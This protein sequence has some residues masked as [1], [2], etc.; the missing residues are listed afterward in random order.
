MFTSL[1]LATL[2]ITAP[3]FLVVICGYFLRRVGLIDDHF[4]GMGSRMVFNFT[5]PILLFVSIATKTLTYGVALQMAGTGV[6]TTLIIW[7]FAAWLAKGWIEP[8]TDRGVVVMGSFRSNLGI[9]GLAYSFNA[10]GD[11]GV[12]AVAMYLAFVTILFNILS[13]VTLSRKQG[14][15]TSLLGTLQGI[16]RNP[17]IVAIALALVWNGLQLPVPQIVLTTGNYFAAMTLPLALLCAGGSLSLAAVKMDV[18]K[19][20]MATLIKLLLTPVVTAVAGYAVGLQ[21]MH[22]ELV[23]LMSCA[24][25]AAA[26]Y[27]MV[28][29]MGGNAQLIASIIASTTL[30]SFASTAVII[31]LMRVMQITYLQS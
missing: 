18:G 7:S 11:E 16:V 9:V 6:I 24:P 17:L 3:I 27:A 12:A 22:L 4:I 19:V 1:L 31:S 23:V 14:G 10:Y 29:A 26:G 5:L 25:S 21:A 20:T 15:D 8:R 30:L 2:A 13:V 28:R